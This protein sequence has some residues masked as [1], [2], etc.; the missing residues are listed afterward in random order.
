MSVASIF[1]SAFASSAAQLFHRPSQQFQQE[2]QQLGQ[3]LQSGNLSAAQTDFATLQHLNGQTAGSTNTNSP[4]AQAFQQLSQ[5]LQSGNLS[6]AQQAFSQIQQDFHNGS[7]HGGHHHD[8]WGENSSNSINQLF[9]QLG[10]ELQSGKLSAAQQAYSTL[11]QDLQ[12]FSS[13]SGGTTSATQS[14]AAA[15]G[16]SVTA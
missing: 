5:E 3:D 1:S 16:F 9:Q 15:S 2:F 4:I 10:Q 13:G 14:P 6:A 8:R 12:L 7:V 11:S